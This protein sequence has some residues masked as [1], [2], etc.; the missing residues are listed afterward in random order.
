MIRAKAD[1]GEVNAALEK[2]M[3]GLHVWGAGNLVM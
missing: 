1:L 2:V 3:E